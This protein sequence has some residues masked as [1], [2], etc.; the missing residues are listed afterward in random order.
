MAGKR[1]Q[2][3]KLDAND[4]EAVSSTE[5][6]NPNKTTPKLITDPEA[7]EYLKNPKLKKTSRI[8]CE[9]DQNSHGDATHFFTPPGGDEVAL[10]KRHLDKAVT[11]SI[12]KGTTIKQRMIKSEDIEPHA[13]K[14]RL[15]MHAQRSAAEAGFRAAGL[16]EEDTLAFRKK[17][18][19]G[20]GRPSHG[21]PI[22]PYSGKEIAENIREKAHPA[23]D[24]LQAVE[25]SGGHNPSKEVNVLKELNIIN[26]QKNKIEQP[27]RYSAKGRIYDLNNK[28]KTKKIPDLESMPTLE[29]IRA[30]NHRKRSEAAKAAPGPTRFKPGSNKN[31]GRANIGVVKPGK[32]EVDP[33][34][35]G[36][37]KI[38]EIKT[39]KQLRGIEDNT[40]A[41]R[42]RSIE[43]AKNDPEYRRQKMK[44]ALAKN[45]KGSAPPFTT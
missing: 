30:E 37:Q 22:S 9:A 43:R 13:R 7:A 31:P 29:E 27:S 26:A 39:E 41:E 34:E 32:P 1:N 19:L 28:G 44:E 6:L 33:L 35:A 4:F 18:T 12:I 14:R 36:F 3:P 40:E 24:V 15:E 20:G 10:C 42:L 21:A 45:R 2:G 16:P 25:Q 23:E 17:K 11:T 38:E 5:S 8:A